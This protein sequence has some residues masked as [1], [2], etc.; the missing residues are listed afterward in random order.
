MVIVVAFALVAIIGA[1]VDVATVYGASGLL[2]VGALL[3]AGAV[4]HKY[5]T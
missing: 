1:T 3:L 4:L 5:F 2:L